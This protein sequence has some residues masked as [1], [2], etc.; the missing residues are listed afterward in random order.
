MRVPKR[1]EEGRTASHSR[2]GF[3]SSEYPA[4]L[5]NQIRPSHP[6]PRKDDEVMLSPRTWVLSLKKVVE[7]RRSTTDPGPWCR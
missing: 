5:K 6:L 1:K 3:E 2:S 7:N 4:I